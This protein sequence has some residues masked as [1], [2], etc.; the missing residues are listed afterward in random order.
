[1]SISMA[2]V[3]RWLKVCGATTTSTSPLT[4]T[5]TMHH[6]ANH[7]NTA[8]EVVCGMQLHTKEQRREW[9]NSGLRRGD[10]S[11]QS[12]PPPPQCRLRRCR[13][14][15]GCE[16]CRGD[17]HRGWD[18]RREGGRVGGGDAAAAGGGEGAR[19]GHRIGMH[20]ECNKIAVCAISATHHIESSVE[21]SLSSNHQRACQS[22]HPIFIA[23]PTHQPTRPTNQ[24]IADESCAG[25]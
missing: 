18:G 4:R 20:E 14:S 16:G 7:C 17:A 8:L 22:L 15:R 9:K 19:D 11:E 1:M 12:N 10:G 6:H 23:P 5:H 2:S 25:S 13:A 3:A 24:P 21:N